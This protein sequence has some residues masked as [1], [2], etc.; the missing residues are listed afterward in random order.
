[1]TDPLIDLVACVVEATAEADTVT[2]AERGDFALPSKPLPRGHGLISVDDRLPVRDGKY[3]VWRAWKSSGI[4]S[5]GV[6]FYFA[7]DESWL[8]DSTVQDAPPIRH[9]GELPRP[10][11]GYRTRKG[12][13]R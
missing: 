3:L 1:M 4:G 13:G 6:A 11:A 8:D 12:D 7:E 9:W 10:P 5:W 2:D